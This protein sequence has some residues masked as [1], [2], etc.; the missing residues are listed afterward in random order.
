F[1][2]ALGMWANTAIFSIVNGV[3]L[4]PLPYTRPE[5]LARVYTEFPT[6]P[7]GG[8]RRFAVS[9]PE[10]LDLRRETRSWESLDVWLTSGANI[11]GKGEP[12]RVTASFVSGELL[13]TLG[14]PPLH[15]RLITQ[16]DDAPGVPQ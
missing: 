7:N 6:F 12:V 15:G 8:L 5:Q 2:L 1:T 13:N 4:R 10:F 14:V 3:I 11:A 9:G 16:A